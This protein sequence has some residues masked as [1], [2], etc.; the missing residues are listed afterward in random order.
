M[1]IIDSSRKIEITVRSVDSIPCSLIGKTMIISADGRV[2]TEPWEL[3]WPMPWIYQACFEYAMKNMDVSCVRTARLYNPDEPDQYIEI[4]ARSF[5][6]LTIGQLLEQ[7]S[8]QYPDEEALVNSTGTRRFVYRQFR[9]VSRDLAKGLI[10]IDVEKSDKVAVWA[11]NSPEFVFSQFGIARA[12]GIMV[13][14]NAYEKERQ[15]EKL[16]KQSDT[17]TL[18]LQIGTKATENIEILYKL[19][20]ELCDAMPGKLKSERLPRLRNVIVI[21]DEEYPGTFRWSEVLNLGKTLGEDALSQREKQLRCQDTVHM[22][23]T[24]GTTGK[25]KGVM[26]SNGN[27]IENAKAMADRMQLTE[28]DIV[29]VQAPMFHCFG[30]IACTLTAVVGGCSMVM[31][32]KF[33]SGS[34]LSLIEREKCT[35]LS[36][37]PT[38]FISFI[39]E[40]AKH[41]YDLSSVRTGI[42]AGASCSPKLVSEIK[43]VLGMKHLIVSYGLTEASPCVTSVYGDDPDEL[44]ANTVGAPL[45]GVELKLVDPV[46]KKEAADGHCGEILVRGYNIMQGYYQMPEETSLA[47]DEEGWLHTGDIGCFYGNGYLCIKDRCKDI[48]IRSGENISPKEIEDFLLAHDAAAEVGVVGIPSYLYGEEVVA[49]IRIREGSAITEKELREYCRG[50]LST[51]KTPKWFIFIEQFPA[52]DSGKCLKS[53]LRQAARELI[54]N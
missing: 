39:E 30:C 33:R 22:I 32:D 43:N 52:S 11:V 16:L 45:P 46:T 8:R 51:N 13:P 49:F 35:V 54:A 10:A 5:I 47:V 23:Y 20:P 6:D 3:P 28:A 1:S 25:P 4:F 2:E 27:I 36:G 34:T 7:V 19:C 21:S 50:R 14:L 53:A 37:V 12:G 26:L 18:I 44:K 41:P 42:I 38:M 9:E 15:M 17:S 24:S 31:V 29:C 40:L 48:I